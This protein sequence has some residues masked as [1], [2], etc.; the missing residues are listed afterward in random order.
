MKTYTEQLE[1]LYEKAR[2]T[3]NEKIRKSKD[4]SK[5][6]SVKVIKITDEQLMFN[7]EGGRYLTE[8]SEENLIDN[9]GYLYNYSVLPYEDFMELADWV[10]TL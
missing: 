1:D 4:K 6:Y 10:K 8:I 2:V 3:I 9:Q 5:S 7:L